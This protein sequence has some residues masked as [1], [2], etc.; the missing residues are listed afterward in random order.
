MWFLCGAGGQEA[1][2]Y[3]LSQDLYLYDEFQTGREPRSRRPS[4]AS[5]YDVFCNIRD[6]ELEHVKTVYQARTNQRPRC[7]WL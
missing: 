4:I 5:L 7:P 3:Y 6:D 1:I 2:D